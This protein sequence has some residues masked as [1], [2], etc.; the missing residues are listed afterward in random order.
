MYIAFDQSGF[1]KDAQLLENSFVDGNFLNVCIHS[2][3][4]LELTTF[5]KAFKE[6]L[7]Q[8]LEFANNLQVHNS[9]NNIKIINLEGYTKLLLK[10]DYSL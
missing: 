7:L 8:Y 5:R 3:F 10:N 4:N 9:C 2:K 6:D 1:I